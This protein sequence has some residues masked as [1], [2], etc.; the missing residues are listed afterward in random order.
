MSSSFY[1]LLLFSVNRL[2]TF[3]E[4]YKGTVSRDIL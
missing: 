4:L 1:F 2:H 3:A